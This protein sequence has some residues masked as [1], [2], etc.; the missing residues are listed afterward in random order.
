MIF[1]DDDEQLIRKLLQ[2]DDRGSLTLNRNSRQVLVTAIAVQDL[3]Y[4]V[5]TELFREV[6]RLLAQA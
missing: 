6:K 3:G 2:E 1:T 5:P 4:E